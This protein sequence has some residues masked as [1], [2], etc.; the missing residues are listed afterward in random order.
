M[1]TSSSHSFPGYV[2]PRRPDE[3]DTGVAAPAQAKASEERKAGGR[4]IPPGA[5]F[6]PQL[7]GRAH[8]HTTRL[9]HRMEPT[10]AIAPEYTKRA[11]AL[12]NALRLEIARTVGGGVCGIAA[13]LFIKFAAQKT[14]AAEAAYA[15][16]AFETHRKL[17]E[18]ARMDILYAREHAAKEAAARPSHTSGRELPPGFTWSDDEDDA[19][20]ASE[21]GQ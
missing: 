7:G 13:S 19:P 16:G 5:R 15:D 4:G 11:R 6:V 3:L 2:E 1:P 14:A 18:S 10:E 12:R 9:S 20:K 21:G 8:K 17:T